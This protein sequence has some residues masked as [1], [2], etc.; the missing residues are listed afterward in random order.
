MRD[1]LEEMEAKRKKER[2]RGKPGQKKEVEGKK[3]AVKENEK[4]VKGEQD[5]VSLKI[6]SPPV[7]MYFLLQPRGRMGMGRRPGE[8]RGSAAT[9]CP[10]SPPQPPPFER[11]K[12]GQFAR[13]EKI[14]LIT[15]HYHQS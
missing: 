6:K 9:W 11:G 3:R 7:E 14:I 10:P 4:G 5:F 15:H 2:G 13:L 1:R 12:G 8:E